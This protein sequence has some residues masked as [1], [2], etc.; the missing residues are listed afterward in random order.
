VLA[1]I[2]MPNLLP[3]GIGMKPTFSLEH[4]FT[5]TSPLGANIWVAKTGA[6]SAGVTFS[7]LQAWTLGVQY[8]NHFTVGD[9]SKYYGNIDRDFFS[10]TLSYEF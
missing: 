4:D 2:D 8:T 10:A 6:A 3:Y 7:Y 5:G 1:I 9:S